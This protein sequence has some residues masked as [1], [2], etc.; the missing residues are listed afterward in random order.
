MNRKESFPIRKRKR[1][2]Q[3]EKLQQRR[4][5]FSKSH[6]RET[7][8]QLHIS[9]SIVCDPEAILYKQSSFMA[10]PPKLTL[11]ASFA[12]SSSSI[13]SSP[14]SWQKEIGL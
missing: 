3:G 5:T 8:G 10:P 13:S 2:R 9:Y 12:H 14:T 7:K 4:P 6:P 11:L 1:P